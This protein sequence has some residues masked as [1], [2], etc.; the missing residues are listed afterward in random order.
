MPGRSARRTSALGPVGPEDVA[1]HLRH[2]ADANADQDEQEDGKVLIKV[3]L[4]IL[5]SVMCFPEYDPGK[6]F[7]LVPSARLEL[8]Q[9]SPLPPQDS[10]STNFTTKAALSCLNC[11]RRLAAL[12][13]SDKLRVYPEFTSSPEGT[14]PFRRN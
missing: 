8:A 6:L 3:H 11:M 5:I 14:R 9:L 13:S 10:V 12:G 4:G 2:N 7:C 1:E